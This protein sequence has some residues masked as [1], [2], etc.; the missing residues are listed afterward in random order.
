MHRG[1]N[2][3]TNLSLN[4]FWI[5]VDKEESEKGITWLAG[6]NSYSG[7]VWVLSGRILVIKLAEWV[8]T[9]QLDWP[10]APTGWAKWAM[11]ERGKPQAGWASA[12]L[13]AHGQWKIETGF[14]V[15]QIF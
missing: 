5:T 9:Q 1:F 3:L 4:W 7:Q 13:P 6:M 12:R 2:I 8:R 10:V 14:P 11:R 15:I